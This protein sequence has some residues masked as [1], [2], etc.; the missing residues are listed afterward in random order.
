MLAF[1]SLKPLLN[2][3][4]VKKAEKVT[5]TAG[6]ILLPENKAIEYNFGTV[7][8]V[9][10]G[11]PN[12]DGKLIPTTVKVGDQVLLP[13]YG[14]TKITLEGDNELFLY[15]DEDIFGTLHDPTK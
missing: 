4:V 13:E 15:R 5:K 2:R 7:L 3:I 12:Q 11:R 1:K 10:P 9:G 14:G 6:G 8:A